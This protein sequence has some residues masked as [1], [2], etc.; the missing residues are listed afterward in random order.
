MINR[1][2]SGVLLLITVLGLALLIS[3][4]MFRGNV[5]ASSG[6][7]AMGDVNGN[8]VV[9]VADAILVLRH[10]VDM[11]KLDSEQLKRADV[12]GDGAVNVGDVVLILRYIVK[13]IDKFPAADTPN[14]PGDDDPGQPDY[15]APDDPD[16]PDDPDEPDDPDKPGYPDDPDEKD[17]PDVPKAPTDPT[18][19]KDPTDPNY[20][21]EP[22]VPDVPDD[23][24]IPDD[25]SIPDV[26]D[27]TDIVITK[28]VLTIDIQDRT[29]I[30]GDKEVWEFTVTGTVDQQA[31]VRVN[32]KLAS[33]TGKNFSGITEL[34]PGW[35]NIRVVAEN[36]EGLRTTKEVAVEYKYCYLDPE[37]VDDLEIVSRGL[38]K[39]IDSL[40]GEEEKEVA[41]AIKKNIDSKLKDYCYDHTQNLSE[42]R[43][44]Y[45]ALGSDQKKKLENA[46]LYN[47]SVQR[48]LRLA[49]YFGF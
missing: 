43:A 19:L 8:G 45:S 1:N 4:V 3:P 18:D 13:L 23:P 16:D 28:P 10:I 37:I 47:I 44:M 21:D 26:T 31:E 2:K 27:D 38:V 25:P 22:D 42:I 32:G 29:L 41:R 49:E 48:L 40:A 39:V 11:S 30:K 12:N 17:D 7:P 6:E 9:T 20:Q 5:Y 36:S 24:V 33:I 34:K 14:Y 35:N 46:I 15:P